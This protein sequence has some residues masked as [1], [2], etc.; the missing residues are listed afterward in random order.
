MIDWSSTAA[1]IALAVAVVTPTI[2]TICNNR[3]Q[4]LMKDMELYTI[5]RNEIIEE[6]LRAASHSL[7]M[8]DEMPEFSTCKATIFLYAPQSQHS[9]IAALNKLIEERS[10]SETTSVLLTSIATALHKSSPR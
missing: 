10:C 9:N 1:W 3:H 4:R 6:Y 8:R 2:T 5:K 7:Y